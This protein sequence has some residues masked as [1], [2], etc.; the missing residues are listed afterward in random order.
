VFDH[1]G[2]P[3]PLRKEA[4]FFYDGDVGALFFPSQIFWLGDVALLRV[5]PTVRREFFNLHSFSGRTRTLLFQLI[6][7]AFLLQ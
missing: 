2:F 5:F 7:E 6:V 3:P 1:K 4:P